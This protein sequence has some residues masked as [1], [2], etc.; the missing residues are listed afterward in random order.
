[1]VIISQDVLRFV[2]GGIGDEGEI[3]VGYRGGRRVRK[4]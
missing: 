3:N 2:L 1:M 4:M